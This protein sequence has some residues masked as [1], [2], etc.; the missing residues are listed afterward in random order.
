[1]SRND[2]RPWKALANGIRRICPHCG[3]GPMLDGWLSVRDRC[4][5][6]G[7]VYERNHGD[8]W[9]FWVIG[10]RIPI[11]IAIV[12]VYFGLQPHTL[13][14]GILFFGTLGALLV[15][16]VPHRMGAILALHYLSRRWWPDPDD[17]VPGDAEAGV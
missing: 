5:E 6:C 10:D 16:T 15:A 8:T 11:A 2:I 9:A 4:P 3:R 17:P 1:M 13:V 7:L 14:A 12:A